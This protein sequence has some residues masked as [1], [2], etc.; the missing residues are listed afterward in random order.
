MFGAPASILRV[1]S[2]MRRPHRHRITP[3]RRAFGWDHAQRES[4][5]AQQAL[6]GTTP[7][8]RSRCPERASSITGLRTTP[9]T[10]G[11]QHNGASY[12]TL[13][14]GLLHDGAGTMG[15]QGAKFG[16]SNRKKGCQP[17][18]PDAERFGIQ[19]PRARWVE[20]SKTQRSRARSGQ[21]QCRV[22]PQPIVGVSLDARYADCEPIW[23][24]C[25]IFSARCSIVSRSIFII[26]AS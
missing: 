6:N 4:H 1:A 15:V 21:L 3:A 22:R 5:P 18:P 7:S 20:P 24:S 25:G 17:C 19:L 13:H 23:I 12:H 14:N 8:T 26:S 16:A 9:R 2:R 10:T 11:N